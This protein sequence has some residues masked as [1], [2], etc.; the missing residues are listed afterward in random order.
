MTQF[1]PA[2]RASPIDT[3]VAAIRVDKA[4]AKIAINW[5]GASGRGAP[6]RCGPRSGAGNLAIDRSPRINVGP[7]RNKLPPI[8]ARVGPDCGEAVDE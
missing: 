2:A 4:R 5:T 6:V 8:P 3:A 7:P 1:G